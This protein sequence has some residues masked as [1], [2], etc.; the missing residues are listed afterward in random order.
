MTGK[1]C[2]RPRDAAPGRAAW[3]GAGDRPG[4]SGLVSAVLCGDLADE[5]GGCGAGQGDVEQ[6]VG[7]GDVAGDVGGGGDGDVAV[8]VLPE[9]GPAIVL[10]FWLISR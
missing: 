7:P 5:V 8:G 2:P 10:V 9:T 3:G 6:L 1:R 4:L